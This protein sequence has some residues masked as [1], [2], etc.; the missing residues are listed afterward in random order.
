VIAKKDLSKNEYEAFATALDKANKDIGRREEL[1]PK[2]FLI[3]FSSTVFRG[4]RF[5]FFV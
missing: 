1:V 3:F 2:I 4:T 5:L